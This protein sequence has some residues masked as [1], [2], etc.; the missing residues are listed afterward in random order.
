MSLGK[1]LNATGKKDR[2]SLPFNKFEQHIRTHQFMAKFCLLNK[3]G[4]RNHWA[5][6]LPSGSFWED[7]IETQSVRHP[8]ERLRFKD[9]DEH[10]IWEKAID[11]SIVGSKS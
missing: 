9:L 11:L 7:W 3:F 5:A 4:Q 10:S 6:D 8:A 1:S 2:L